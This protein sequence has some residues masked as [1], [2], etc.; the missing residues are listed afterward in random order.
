MLLKLL[1]FYLIERD[2]LRPEKAMQIHYT[3]AGGI[4]GHVMLFCMVIIYTFAHQ[5][6]RHQSYE[7]FQ[8]S[9]RLFL[10]FLLAAWSHGSGC[11]IR[12]TVQPYEITDPKDYWAHCVGYQSWRWET[13]FSVLYILE[14]IY[15]H[16]YCQQKVHVSRVLQHPSNVLEIQFDREGM[17][18]RAGQWVFIKCPTLS[19]S[20]WHPFSISSCPYDPYVSVHIRQVGDFTRA[21]G[22]CFKPGIKPDYDNMDFDP[23]QRTTS[24]ITVRD[25]YQEMPQIIVE[26]PYGSPAEDIFGNEVA[27]LVGA[28]IGVTPWAS[29]LKSLWHMRDPRFRGAGH[30]LRRVEFI[31]TCKGLTEFEWF[32]NLITS[33][34]DQSLALDS[35]DRSIRLYCHTFITRPDDASLKVYKEALE[36]RKTVRSVRSMAHQDRLK[37]IDSGKKMREH[38]NIHTGRPDFKQIF[39]DIR[40]DLEIAR[41]NSSL[42]GRLARRNQIAVNFCGPKPMAKD[43]KAACVEMTTNDVKFK[44]K[45]E[46]F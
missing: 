11:F 33:L 31:W 8:W 10:V 18:Y 42:R 5:K 34:N 29:V 14:R 38:N 13:W 16:F 23:L 26:G 21:I 30:R 22:D 24:I 15:A 32:Q 17:E 19:K 1:S 20:Q 43:I 35:S 9:H 44:F 46:S 41:D 39:R 7:A 3:Q 45:K 40:D 36:R 28:G 2:Q 12:N 25:Q 6:I 4:T 27:I 37:R